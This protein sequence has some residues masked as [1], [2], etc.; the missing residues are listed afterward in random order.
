[1]HVVGIALANVVNFMNPDV[2]V[3]GGGLVNEMPELVI[4]EIES[5]M[6]EYL[7]PEVGE[8]LK[9]KRARLQNAVVALGAAHQALKAAD[10]LNR[11]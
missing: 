10:K 4:A 3:L 11:K 9:V 7:T 5:G 8:V 1:M 6:R 2:V